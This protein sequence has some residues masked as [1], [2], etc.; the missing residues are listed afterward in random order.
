MSDLQID[1]VSPQEAAA[2][3]RAFAAEIARKAVVE[4]PERPKRPRQTE[5]EIIEEPYK[6][7]RLCVPVVFGSWGHQWDAYLIDRSLDEGRVIVCLRTGRIAANGE[8]TKLSSLSFMVAV[9][10]FGADQ[11]F[12]SYED[13]VDLVYQGQRN[14]DFD[15]AIKG[16]Q[17]RLHNIGMPM[18]WLGFEIENHSGNGYFLRRRQFDECE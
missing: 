13:L 11:N 17:K 16:I 6:A 2:R 8:L 15:A 5:C 3:R 14:N 12:V 18:K 4:K 1:Y 9:A 7:P 10:L